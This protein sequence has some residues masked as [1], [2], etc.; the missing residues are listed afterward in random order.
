MENEIPI[1]L[2][3]PYYTPKMYGSAQTSS[4]DVS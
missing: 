1:K 4:M 2:I 3:L